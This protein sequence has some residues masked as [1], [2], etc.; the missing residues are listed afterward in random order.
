MTF[1]YIDQPTVQRADGVFFTA[2]E[3]P[4]TT[5]PNPFTG[6]QGQR[7]TVRVALRQSGYDKVK[8]SILGLVNPT[9]E[10]R[11]GYGVQTNP[12]VISFTAEWRMMVDIP[13]FVNETIPLW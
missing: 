10:G 5:N 9:P 2:A 6:V 4:G 3:G 11:P 8:W 12:P 13:F 7:Y 1:A